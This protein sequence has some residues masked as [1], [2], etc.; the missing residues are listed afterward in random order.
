MRFA[1]STANEFVEKSVLEAGEEG[2]GEIVLGEEAV[3]GA[4]SY[5]EYVSPRPNLVI[6]S[7]TVSI[8]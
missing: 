2:R 3:R 8:D 7:L 4:F 6:I 1:Y 5:I